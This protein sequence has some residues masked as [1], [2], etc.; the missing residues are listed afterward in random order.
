M[1]SLGVS[2]VGTEWKEQGSWSTEEAF[3]HDMYRAQQLINLVSPCN[4]FSSKNI[5]PHEAILF[6]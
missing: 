6:K 3:D 2:H 1:L 5:A 4:Q